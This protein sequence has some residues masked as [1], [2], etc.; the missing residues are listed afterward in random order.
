MIPA[1]MHPS[2]TVLSDINSSWHRL[3]PIAQRTQR[4]AMDCF[5]W[6][7]ARNGSHDVPRC[8]VSLPGLD[9]TGFSF[10]ANFRFRRS[11]V[12][13]QPKGR[14]EGRT[15]NP[16]KTSGLIEEKIPRR[17]GGLVVW[18]FWWFWWF[19]LSLVHP[20]KATLKTHEKMRHPRFLRCQIRLRPPPGGCPRFGDR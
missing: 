15:D 11:R 5:W 3:F 8:A 12:M 19:G 6:L 18:W 9:L 2:L 10:L 13:S 1:R 14:P 20:K 17:L 16:F 4:K 7:R